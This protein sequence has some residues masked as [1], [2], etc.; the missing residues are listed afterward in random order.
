M[1]RIREGLRVADADLV[2]LQEVGVAHGSDNRRWISTRCWP[3]GFG[4][5]HAYGRNAVKTRGHHGNAILSKYPITS[6]QN[7]DISVGTSEPRGLLHCILR[8]PRTTI[9]LHAICVHLALRESHRVQ[10]VGR[11]LEL[12][13]DRIPHGAPIV[14]AGDFN[15][16]QE[17]ANLRMLRDGASR[18]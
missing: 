14:I 9:P 18:K 12:V 13:A 10:Q 17:R 5:Q 15:D 8:I 7:V 11:L 1:L 2:F 6:W 4:A 3:I 16:W